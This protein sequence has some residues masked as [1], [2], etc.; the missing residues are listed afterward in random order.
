MGTIVARLL[1]LSWVRF[2]EPEIV[3]ISAIST[4]NYHSFVVRMF[5]EMVN[6]FNTEMILQSDLHDT[7]SITQQVDF[8]G[9]LMLNEMV[10]RK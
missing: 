6:Q 1:A 3:N 8:D 2:F 4:H 9:E 7:V 10:A 5:K